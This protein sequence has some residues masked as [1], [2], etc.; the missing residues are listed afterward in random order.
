MEILNA[1][2]LHLSCFLSSGLC[3]LALAEASVCY[4][5]PRPCAST[6][7]EAPTRPKRYLDKHIALCSPPLT[8]EVFLSADQFLLQQHAPHSQATLNLG[9]PCTSAAMIRS[10]LSVQPELIKHLPY[11]S[12]GLG[13]GNE[14][15][16]SVD[17]EPLELNP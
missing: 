11:T 3:V 17:F 14:N 7:A 6:A 8:F 9:S 1:F 16:S 4:Q 15:G 12:H 13:S 10:L 5:P 2:C